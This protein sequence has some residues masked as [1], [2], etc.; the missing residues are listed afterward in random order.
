MI[1][2]QANKTYKIYY[3][4]DYEAYIVDNYISESLPLDGWIKCCINCETYTSKYII[5]HYLGEP[6]VINV[7]NNCRRRKQMAVD[8]GISKLFKKISL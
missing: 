2:L 8:I 4:H 3:C 5:R 6:I 1:P 7:C